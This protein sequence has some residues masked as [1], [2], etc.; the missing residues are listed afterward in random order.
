MGSGQSKMLHNEPLNPEF[1]ERGD[2]EAVQQPNYKTDADP[3]NSN[4]QTSTEDPSTTAFTNNPT[5]PTGDTSSDSDDEHIS[6]E[7]ESVQNWERV[8]LDKI[9][10][11]TK[12]QKVPSVYTVE[13]NDNHINDVNDHSKQTP[14]YRTADNN[15]AKSDTICKPT[16]FNRRIAHHI[17]SGQRVTTI[18]AQFKDNKKQQ[19][20]DALQTLDGVENQDLLWERFD[21]FCNK[22]DKLKHKLNVQ[23]N[24]LSNEQMVANVANMSS[25]THR[26]LGINN[27]HCLRH[28]HETRGNIE[29]SL[30]TIKQLDHQIQKT[31][32]QY[33]QLEDRCRS[34]D[35][36]LNFCSNDPELS[37]LD[38]YLT[39]ASR[40]T[41]NLVNKFLQKKTKQVAILLELPLEQQRQVCQ[42]LE[43]ERQYKAVKNSIE[44]TFIEPQ[45]IKAIH[46]DRLVKREQNA[47][48]AKKPHTNPSYQSIQGKY[49][50]LLRRLNPP[51]TYY[52]KPED[53]QDNNID[54]QY[55]KFQGRVLKA[56]VDRYHFWHDYDEQVINAAH[57]FKSLQKELDDIQYSL[58]NMHCESFQKLKQ[59]CMQDS[60]VCAGLIGFGLVLSFT[61]AIAG[62][63]IGLCLTIPATI[64]L[65][66]T[67]FNYENQQAQDSAIN[68]VNEYDSYCDNELYFDSN[69]KDNRKSPEYFRQQ[70]YNTFFAPNKLFDETEQ[71]KTDHMTN[72]ETLHKRDSCTF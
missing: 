37:K 11:K 36:F 54:N 30:Q 55:T 21:A 52:I 65:Y 38:N 50:G 17:A 14:Q 24:Q 70:A 64:W 49:K 57:K 13:R 56:L 61:H 22:I 29:Q 69:Q 42:L 23:V 67:W 47:L 72:D 25:K 44:P 27:P 1:V 41:K 39:K 7:G 40:S 32:D 5:P 18:L 12:N 20:A 62:P 45:H 53:I 60:A 19:I 48:H 66:Q 63:I 28:D 33:K 51:Q 8:S 31:Y 4:Q 26:E 46:E 43:L 16:G 71:A 15:I 58:N 2:L 59:K 68:L 6:P 10:D 3:N 35:E 9:D 34:A